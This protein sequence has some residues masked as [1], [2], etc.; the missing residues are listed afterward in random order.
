MKQFQLSSKIGVI[1]E[2]LAKKYI[3]GLGHKVL[4]TNY[5]YEKG[6]RS[7]EIDIITQ[8]K[9]VLHFIEVKTKHVLEKPEKS[10]TLYSYPIEAQVTPSKIRKCLKTVQHYLRVTKNQNTEYHFDILTVLYNSGEK[11]AHIQYLQ[12]V[13]Y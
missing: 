8:F 7:G 11:K 12:D 1:G 9:G 3:E 4:N 5:Y 6:K 10:A 13:F 2:A